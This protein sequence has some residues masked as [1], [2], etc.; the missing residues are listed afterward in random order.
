LADEADC[1]TDIAQSGRC[2][3][4]YLCVR[5]DASLATHMIL[6]GETAG[7]GG[8]ACAWSLGLSVC[9][10]VLSLISVLDL[11]VP[12]VGDMMDGGVPLGKALRPLGL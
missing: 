2:H 12:L 1:R 3:A 8:G 6:L 5:L 11:G 4:P 7:L 10:R 9:V